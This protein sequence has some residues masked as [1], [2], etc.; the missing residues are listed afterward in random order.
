MIV[1]VKFHRVANFYFLGIFI[2]QVLIDSPVS[3]YTSGLPLCFVIGLTAIKQAYEDWLRY[4]E[5]Q[6]ENTKP[7]YI[8][9]SGVLVRDQCMNIRP[10]DI[11]RVNED[12][13]IP[14]DLVLISSSEKRAH[15]YYRSELHIPPMNQKIPI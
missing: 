15:A 2:M 6:K 9:R 12:A 4:R 7:V 11:V 5:D 8:V 13:T 1:I 10:G 14:A 3:P